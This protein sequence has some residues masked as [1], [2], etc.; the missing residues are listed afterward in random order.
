MFVIFI[1]IFVIMIIDKWCNERW[2]SFCNTTLIVW[3][4][5]QKDDVDRRVVVSFMRFVYVLVWIV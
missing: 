1:E 5:E 3:L 2:G 4:A